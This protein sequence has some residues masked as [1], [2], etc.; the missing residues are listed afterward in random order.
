[1]LPR[2]QTQPGRQ[3]PPV[4]DALASATAVTIAVAVIQ[5]DRLQCHQVPLL[6]Q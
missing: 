5:S 4:A 1:M 2:D 3:L 6:T